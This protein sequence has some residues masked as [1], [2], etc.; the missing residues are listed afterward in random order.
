MV[1]IEETAYDGMWIT[2]DY[3]K[4]FRL[5]K[6]NETGSQNEEM[7]GEGKE[8]T[9]ILMKIVEFRIAKLDGTMSLQEFIQKS[10][11]IH[12][13]VMGTIGELTLKQLQQAQ[14]QSQAKKPMEVVQ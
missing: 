8:L 2:H 14:Q 10:D 4:K 13:E 1:R 7:I 3:A 6:K 5:W 11:S 12:Q 9:P